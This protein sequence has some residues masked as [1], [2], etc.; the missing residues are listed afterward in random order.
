MA[1]ENDKLQ[2]LRAK[3]AIKIQQISQNFKSAE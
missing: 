2:S 3:A 1:K